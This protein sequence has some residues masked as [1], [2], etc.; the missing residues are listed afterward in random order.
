MYNTK[1]NISLSYLRTDTCVMSSSKKL[2][3][4]TLLM[5]L[6]RYKHYLQKINCTR[7][8]L[9]FSMIDSMLP[10]WRLGKLE[11]EAITMDFQK[12]N[13]LPNITMN[14]V[15][16][17]QLSIFSFNIHANQHFLNILKI[18]QKSSQRSVIVSLL[19]Y[20]QWTTGGS[21]SSSHFLW[22]GWRLK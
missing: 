17:R 4:F 5:P 13:S 8:M 16:Y 14:D 21:A 10:E 1:F 6:V 3:P 19:L 11:Y 15:Y 7:F 12:N 18:R 22:L 2:K 20:F 9:Q